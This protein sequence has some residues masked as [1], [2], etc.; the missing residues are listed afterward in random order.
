MKEKAVKYGLDALS[1]H[2]VLELVLYYG[3]PY[4]NTNGIGHKLMN[5]FGSLASVFEADRD[6][7]VKIEGIGEHT[8]TLIGLIPQLCGRYNRDRASVGRVYDLEMIKEYVINHFIGA[9]K[10][11][12]EL[13]LFDDS[14][15]MAE[16]LTLQEGTLS[17]SGIAP[18]LIGEHIFRTKAVYFLLAHNHQSSVEP[19]YEDLMVTRNIQRSFLPLNKHL[20]EHYI[21]S[22]D[23]CIGIREQAEAMYDK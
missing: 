9:T 4:K 18:E 16:H 3:I 22:G 23:R 11:H 19:S 17:Q 1:D 2:E 13:F 20:I 7:L 14:M 6:E 12:T 10:E 5:R 15:R 8:A 21:I